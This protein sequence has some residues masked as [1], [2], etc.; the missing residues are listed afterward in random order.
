MNTRTSSSI[1]GAL[2]LL[3]TL[4]LILV[5]QASVAHG[6][7]R[8]LVRP[9]EEGVAQSQS[10][11]MISLQSH[12]NRMGQI[13]LAP[14][15]LTAYGSASNSKAGIRSSTE[16]LFLISFFADA[17]Y[18]VIIEQINTQADGTRIVS[19]KIRDHNLK[20]FVLTIATDGF[21]LALQDMNRNLL[22][23][24]TG[25]PSSGLGMVTEID[26]KKIPSMIR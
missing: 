4:F 24:A 23:R 16:D 8:W 15:S 20:T 21:V 19:G 17:N 1:R 18:E 10:K 22:Y 3:K 13:I 26:M 14:E 12:E 11:S 5:V 7:D 2:W 6:A 9:Q 25:N